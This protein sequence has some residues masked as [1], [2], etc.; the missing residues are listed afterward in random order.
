MNTPKAFANL[1]PGFE[2]ARTLGKLTK[3]MYLTL[4][5]F[6]NRRT[7]SGFERFYVNGPRVV[8]ALQPWAQISERLRRSSVRSYQEAEIPGSGQHD[9]PRRSASRT[10]SSVLSSELRSLYLRGL[11]LPSPS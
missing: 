3:K 11:D 1:S 2:S 9:R 4:K 8:A 7:P 5:G 6:A 10:Q